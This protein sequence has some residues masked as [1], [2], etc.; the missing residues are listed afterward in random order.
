MGRQRRERGGRGR[1]GKRGRTRDVRIKG[2]GSERRKG[3]E[4][5]REGGREERRK[6]EGITGMKEKWMER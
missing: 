4:E 6:G 2:G 1:V 5:N 3:S